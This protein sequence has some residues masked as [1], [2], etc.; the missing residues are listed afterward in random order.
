MMSPHKKRWPRTGNSPLANTLA[1]GMLTA[2]LVFYGVANA[3]ESRETKEQRVAD[4][5]QTNQRSEPSPRA[6]KAVSTQAVTQAPDI[7][8]PADESV[9]T[10]QQPAEQRPDQQNAAQQSSEQQSREQRRAE[11]KQQVRPSKEQPEEAKPEAQKEEQKEQAIEESKGQLTGSNT[12]QTAQPAAQKDTADTKATQRPLARPSIP[13]S[14][15]TANLTTSAV[16]PLPNK[17][18]IPSGNTPNK[19][20]NFEPGELMLVSADM[21]AAK[22]AAS[23]LTRYGAQIKTRTMLKNLGLVMSVFRLPEGEDTRALIQQIQTDL[24]SLQT[25]TNQRYQLQNRR[26]TYGASMVRWPQTLTC[27]AQ[28]TLR[29]GVIDTPVN[30]AHPAL[31]GADIQARSFI[32]GE[33]ASA[34]H[35]TA[36]ASILV[37]RGGFAGLL[38]QAQVSAAGVFRQRGKQVEATT[39]SLLQALDWLVQQQVAVINLSLGG[40]HNRVLAQAIQQVLASNIALVAAAGNSGP[41]APPV[42]PAAQAG[43]IAVTAV[44]AAGRLYGQANH[45]GYIQFAAPGVDIWAADGEQGG[46]YHTGTSFAAP[47]LT[48]A[49]ALTTLQQ[50]QN[51]AQDKGPTGKD[52]QYGYGL[53]TLPTLCQ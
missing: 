44:D 30:T 23:D 32:T 48:A 16:P 34:T 20:A 24:P 26:K 2:G 8:Q 22:R 50:L 38:P 37:G 47:Y 29:V 31:L 28:N 14:P 19:N 33:P 12:Q 25:D 52:P 35:G 13:P 43:V 45:G 39:D 4:G 53:L 3:Q 27:V 5:V 6:I 9:T 46:Q 51:Q 11:T 18:T 1:C 41:E 49:L 21:R 10:A 42:Y 40:E 17:A 15:I 36:V 7:S